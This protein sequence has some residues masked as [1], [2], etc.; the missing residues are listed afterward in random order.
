MRRIR[1]SVIL[2]LVLTLTGRCICA[3]TALVPPTREDASQQQDSDSP[4]PSADSTSRN[5]SP[6]TQPS[7]WELSMWATEAIGNSAYGNVGDAFISMAGFR[8]G[9]VF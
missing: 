9:Y 2:G 5:I 1:T 6:L 3:Q 4:P 7:T 8:A